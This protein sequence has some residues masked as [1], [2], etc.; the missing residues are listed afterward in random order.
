MLEMI[1][2]FKF[3]I[4]D[5]FLMMRSFFGRKNVKWSWWCLEVFIGEFLMMRELA[6]KESLARKPG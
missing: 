4:R 5:K 1:R 2:E 3:S 6:M